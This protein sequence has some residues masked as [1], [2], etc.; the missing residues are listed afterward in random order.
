M[1]KTMILAL[2][3]LTA[4]LLAI[5]AGAGAGAATQTPIS[6][7]TGFS[8]M[9][10]GTPLVTPSGVVHEVGS[11]AGLWYSGDVSGS[12][13]CTYSPNTITTVGDSLLLVARCSTAGTLTWDGRTGPVTGTANIRC[14][15]GFPYEVFSCDGTGMFHGSGELGGVTIRMTSVQGLFPSMAPFSYEGFAI[16]PNG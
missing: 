16:D 6:G 3:A 9:T 15:A 8:W 1:R 14:L 12:V 11:I 5:P 2:A 13:T 10:P 7:S 4:G